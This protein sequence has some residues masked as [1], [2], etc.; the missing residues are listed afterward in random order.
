MVNTGELKKAP[1]YAIDKA[2]EM[3]SV[4]LGRKAMRI[5]RTGTKFTQPYL[6]IEFD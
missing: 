5:G 3:L 4:T 1:E 2:A 6:W